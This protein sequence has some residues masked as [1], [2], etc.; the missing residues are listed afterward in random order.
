MTTPSDQRCVRDRRVKRFVALGAAV[1]LGAG[2]LVVTSPAASAAVPTFPDNIVVFPDRDFISVEGYSAHAGETALAEVTRPGTGVIGSAKVTV[3]GTDVAFEVNHPGGACWGAGTSL[4]VTPDI[5]AGDVVS[6]T[7]PDGSHDETTTSSAT[8]S[9][10][11]TQSGTTVTVEGTIGSD[12][13]PAQLEQRIINAD[14]VPI[15]GKRDVRALPGPI[16]PAPRGGYSSGM[17]VD[18]AAGTFVATYQFDTLEAADTTAASQL[19]E[20]AMSWQV[21]DADANRQGLTIAE[22]GE[23]GGPGM[24]GCPAGPAEQASPAGTASAVRSADKIVVKWTPVAAQ[25]GADPVTG[26]SVEA[27]GATAASGEASVDGVRTA[28]SATQ[29]TL[30]GLDPVAPYT[31]EVRSLSGLKASVPFSMATVSAPGDTTPPT[32]DLVPAPSTDGSAVLTS[33]VT[34]NSNGQVW[35]TTD[36]S[37][38]V[39]GDLPTDTAKFYTGPIP[40]TGP[41]DLR[42]VSFDAANNLQGPVNGLYDVAALPAPPAAPTGLVST[43][44]TQTSV[45]LR[46]D[47]S[48]DPT[49]TGYQVNVYAADGTKAAS[50][51]PVTTVPNQTVTGLTSGT[52]YGFGVQARGA[53]GLG[54]ESTRI[55]EATD[56]AT[57]QVTISTAKWKSGDFKVVGT[58][59]RVGAVIQLSRVNTDGTRGPAIAGATAAVVAAAPPGIGDWT[60]RLRN[61]AAGT[62]N[63]GRIF[64]V[65]DGGGVAGPFTVSNG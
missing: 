14:L 13:V 48:T 26:Y 35:Y 55:S 19:G 30:T 8:V 37:P 5:K 39:S 27:I 1:G 32:L 33:S 56:P 46:W 49:V 24:G 4:N 18:A 15:I 6:V 41:T 58:G 45:A 31:V 64:A 40:I 22:F 17:A 38:V 51:P 57:D 28:A 12:V 43:G 65:S 36:G 20:R 54:D 3:S 62:S 34:V 61:A 29:T 59:S 53:G 10:D 52:T 11:M 23:A 44:K 63:P 50:Q 7:F 42:V 25:P 2:A 47:A 9:K 21:E 16:V 60:I